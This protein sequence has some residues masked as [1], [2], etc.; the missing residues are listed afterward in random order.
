M[1]EIREFIYFL[2]DNEMHVEQRVTHEYHGLTHDYD[3]YLTEEEV[4]EKYEKFLSM[5]TLQDKPEA[6]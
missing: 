6:L 2:Y 4:Y 1:D 3:M 5:K